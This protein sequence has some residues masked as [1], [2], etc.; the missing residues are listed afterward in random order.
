[1]RT[2][3]TLRS[4]GT[5]EDDMLALAWSID[6]RATLP[7]FVHVE[8]RMQRQVGKMQASPEHGTIGIKDGFTACTSSVSGSAA[9]WMRSASETYAQRRKL[10]PS[11]ARGRGRGLRGCS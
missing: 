1:V 7:A 4:L 2:H 11:H 10:S 6:Q 3:A 9:R 5:G 8:H